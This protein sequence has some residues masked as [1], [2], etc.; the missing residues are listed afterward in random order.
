VKII[1]SPFTAPYKQ[2]FFSAHAVESWLVTNEVRN[3]VV[4]FIFDLKNIHSGYIC[5]GACFG[6]ACCFVGGRRV[7]RGRS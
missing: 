6:H 4:R 3:R 1:W 7:H 2:C 5:I